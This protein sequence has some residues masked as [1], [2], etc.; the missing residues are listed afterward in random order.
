ME[1]QGLVEHFD[2]SHSANAFDQGFFDEVYHFV[3]CD[4]TLNYV[5]GLLLS[6]F[7]ALLQCFVPLLLTFALLTDVTSWDFDIPFHCGCSSF[8]R[9]NFLRVNTYPRPLSVEQEKIFALLNRV[10]NGF[11]LFDFYVLFLGTFM[12]LLSL[13]RRPLLFHLCFLLSNPFMDRQSLFVDPHK[14]FSLIVFEFG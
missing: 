9:S 11:L 7:N 8:N 14:G 2:S 3:A 4:V 13:L 12:L 6:T 5:E 10:F 1:Q